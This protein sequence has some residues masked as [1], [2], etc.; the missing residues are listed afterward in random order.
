[1]LHGELSLHGATRPLDV[2]FHA[3]PDA[4]NFRVRGSVRFRQTDFGMKPFST[5]GGS[6]GVDDEIEVDFEL[7]LLPEPGATL[8][9]GLRGE[10]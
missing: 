3:H 9:L 7:V 8:S 1:M 6:I 2:S 10:R 5:A 4:P